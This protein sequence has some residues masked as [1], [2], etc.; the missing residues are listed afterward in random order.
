MISLKYT[1]GFF[2]KEASYV[3]IDSLGHRAVLR[4]NYQKGEYSLEGETLEEKVRDEII[5]AVEDMLA[6][7]HNHNFAN[8]K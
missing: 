1:Q 7:K 6:R 5:L 3:I 8:S 4:V 2:F